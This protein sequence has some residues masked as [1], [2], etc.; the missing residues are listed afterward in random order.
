[1]DSTT[2][3]TKYTAMYNNTFKTYCHGKDID[4]LYE[5]ELY[6][7]KD[8]NKTD[9]NFNPEKSNYSDKYNKTDININIGQ[10]NLLNSL[11]SNNNINYNNK[12]ELNK[13]GPM[14]KITEDDREN[15]E[16][17]LNE[18]PK[19]FDEYD[20]QYVKINILIIISFI[21]QRNIICWNCK[22]AFTGGKTW[23]KVTC[24]KCKELNIVPLDENDRVGEWERF[25]EIR[26]IKVTCP[27]C[28][29]NIYC[30]RESE[31]VTCSECHCIMTIVKEVPLRPGAYEHKFTASIAIKNIN[32]NN[33]NNNSNKM[34]KWSGGY[35]KF[36]PFQDLIDLSKKNEK[37]IK[38]IINK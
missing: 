32:D 27:N 23:E 24:P 28:K 18:E 22:T 33:K 5:K 31:H 26:H 14:P 8:K 15:E 9:Q 38:N 20:E 35:H 10:I 37:N 29:K 21:F 2:S 3:T 17:F 1:M 11:D 6:N 19:Y 13:D 16:T 34:P 4:N 7:E 30:S 25:L 36:D 12:Y